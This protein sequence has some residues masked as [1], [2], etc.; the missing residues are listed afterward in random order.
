MPRTTVP[1][2]TLTVDDTTVRI[3][4]DGPQTLVMVHGWPDTAALWDPQVAHFR[5]RFRCVRFTLPGFDI[6]APRRAPD[7][8]AM[9][10]HLAAIVDA[11][12]PDAPVT[13]LLHDWGA[14]YGY[15][16]ALRHADRVARVIALDIGDTA[17]G[18]FL[19]GLGLGAKLGILAYQGWLALAYQLPRAMGD[20]MTRWMA[21]QLRAPGDPATIGASMNYPYVAQFS[22]GFKAALRVKP[23]WPLLFAYGTRKPF[24]FHARAWTER[25]AATPGNMVLPLHA[26]H[27]VMINRPAELHAAMDDWLAR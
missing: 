23:A 3:E 11:V 15:Q 12:S 24:M 21:R 25:V 8:D 10:A 27:W 22:G 14:V 13:L 9:V 2:S 17:S 19:R 16:Y 6:T 20:G 26:G 4:G 1:E 5:D 7:L 18:E